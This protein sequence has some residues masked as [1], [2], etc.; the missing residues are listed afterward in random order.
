MNNIKYLESEKTI[1]N[2]HASNVK[3]LSVHIGKFRNNY[4]KNETKIKSFELT[5]QRIIPLDAKGEEYIQGFGLFTP[6]NYMSY[7]YKYIFYNY[8]SFINFCKGNIIRSNE[9]YKEGMIKRTGF[10]GQKL[11]QY[12][13]SGE[14]VQSINIVNEIGY[15]REKHEKL[16][17]YP[18]TA[19]N[20]DT[21]DAGSSLDLYISM[22]NVNTSQLD[23][24]KYLKEHNH[25]FG[26]A[27]NK[28]ISIAHQ[29]FFLIDQNYKDNDDW[30]AF[31]K[32][33]A[34]NTDKVNEN[35]KGPKDVSNLYQQ[36]LGI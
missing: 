13:T 18:I 32:E 6:D 19:D 26:S 3:S 31:I 24:S 14:Y 10:T 15:A 1:L 36:F 11:L 7:R 20:F 25:T 16:D 30:K 34:V 23:Q 29:I 35:F 5:D 2:C 28:K 9:F 8:D 4:E 17:T 12:Y 21:T 33:I 22:Y 27:V